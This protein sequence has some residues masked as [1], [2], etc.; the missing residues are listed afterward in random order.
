[1]TRHRRRIA[2]VSLLCLLSACFAAQAADWS[3]TS[4]AWRAGDRFREPHNPNAI[5]KQIA[6]LTHASGWRYGSQFLNLDL[7]QS[8]HR[9]PAS[10]GGRK[11]AFEAYLVYRHTLDVARLAD[12]HLPGPMR[13]LGLTAGIDLNAKDDAAYNSRKR[14]WV[15]GPQVSWAVPGRLNTALLIAWE[16][17]APHGPFPPISGVQGRY[18]YK[19]HP[20]L[21][22]DWSVPVGEHWAFEGFANFIASK[23]RDEAG[24]A[25]GAETNIDARLML[26]AGALL[27]ARKRAFLA[28]IE[29]QYWHNK[30]GNTDATTGNRG[31]TASTPMLRVEHHF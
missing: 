7:L 21:A 12:L 26:D 30:F 1:M 11:G 23:G 28:G 22:A 8:D 16:S 29:Y 19:P 2:R 31:N 5:G 14:M 13:G 27:G 6:S 24:R 18:R 10:P 4:V 20:L 17:N 15:L 9:D 25:T 3:D